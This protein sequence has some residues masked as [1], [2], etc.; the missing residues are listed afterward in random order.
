MTKIV[1][2]GCCEYHYFHNFDEA[3]EF[4]E[5]E[6]GYE[7]EAWEIVKQIKD[8]HELEEFLLDDGIYANVKNE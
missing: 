4:C 2:E 5:S 8:F 3:I 7:G 1:I 6:Y